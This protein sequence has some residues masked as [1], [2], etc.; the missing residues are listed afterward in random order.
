MDRALSFPRPSCFTSDPVGGVLAPAAMIDPAV[1]LSVISMSATAAGMR[2]GQQ[3]RNALSQALY[4]QANRLLRGRLGNHPSTDETI[5]AATTLWVVSLPFGNETVVIQNRTVVRDLVTKR[6]GPF[7]LGGV[8]AEYI[9][10]AE[11][12]S[13]LWLNNEPYILSE[14]IPGFLIAP[15]PIIY[16]AA[17]HSPHALESLH[18]ST[19]EIC[20]TMCRLTELLEKAVRE[21]ATPQ[22]YIYFYSTLKWVSIQ[23]ARFRA[24]CYNSGTKDECISNVIE[25]FRINVF[26]TQPENKSFNSRFCSQ[27]R[28]ALLRTNIT[29]YWDEQIQILIWALFV[30]GTIDYKWES[31]HW[32]MD[33]LR[34]SIS[35]RYANR[36]WPSTWREEA[37]QNL[38]S[39]LWSELRFAEPFVR[40]CDE[41]EHLPIPHAETEMDRCLA[42]G[43]HQDFRHRNDTSDIVSSSISEH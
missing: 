42:I 35:Y 7:L 18:P 19:I 23:R 5:I 37:L 1:C 28:S 40:I 26:S 6:G 29:S 24:G 25:I 11:I 10:W 30:V 13:A 38:T 32:F 43:E 12:L 9:T 15:P 39:F 36:D 3:A 41:L 20:L 34:Q 2:I 22:E 21:D 16:G 4:S 31:R 27:L 17:F 8:L 14:A 33:L